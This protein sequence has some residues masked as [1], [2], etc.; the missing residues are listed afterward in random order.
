VYIF[1]I[2]FI[3]SSA[4]KHVDGFHNLA[5]VKSA[6]IKNDVQV[7]L[8]YADSFQDWYGCVL[9]TP[10]GEREFMRG[11]SNSKSMEDTKYVPKFTFGQINYYWF[12]IVSLLASGRLISHT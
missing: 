10:Q 9:L 6:T 8:V 12:L 7:P 2:F 4:D 1:H 11:G 5:I 3:H